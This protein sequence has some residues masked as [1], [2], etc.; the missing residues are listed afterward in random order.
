MTPQSIFEKKQNGEK[1]VALTAYDFPSARGLD[2]QSI[3]I[4]LV[5][6]SVGMVLLGHDSTV[7]VTMDDIL[8]HTRAVS[9][10]VKNTLLVADMPYGSYD[11]P[12]A[13]L[14]NARRLIEEGG[15]HAVKLEGGTQ[16]CEQVRELRKAGIAV[17]GHIGMLP[18]SVSGAGGFKVQ[19]RKPEEAD[20]LVREAELLDGLGV[21]AL[22]LEC[23]PKALGEAVTKRVKCPTI[24]IGAGPGTDGQILVLHDLLGFKGKVRPKFVRIYGDFEEEMKRAVAH[25]RKDVLSG[26]FPSDRESY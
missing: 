1:I 20:A 12:D 24:G 14:R 16:C 7:A 25:Y 8:H 3:D 23:V 26:G 2:E 17:M 21:F 19:G 9:K 15:A 10:A 18:Q 11:S 22:I 4:I 6:D 5:G 13:A